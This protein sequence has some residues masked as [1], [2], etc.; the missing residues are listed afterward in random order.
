[1]FAPKPTRRA[2][3]QRAAIF[4]AATSLGCHSQASEAAKPANRSK[5][6][7]AMAPMTKGKIGFM[8]DEGD[9]HQRTWMAFGASVPIWGKALLPQ[10]QRNLAEL[11]KTIARYEPVSMLVRPYDYDLAHRLVG[12][13]VEL[14]I[15][16][17]D[18]LWIRD[19]G[20]VFVVTATGEK[21]ATQLNFNG[22]GRK[23]THA[24]DRLLAAFIAQQAGVPLLTTDLVLE[25]GCIEV[26]GQGTALIT[27]S[28][29]LNANRNPGIS[30]AQ[31][32]DQLMPL[33][34]LE[35]IIWLPGIRGADI[36][37]GHTDFYARF[38]G[39]GKVLAGYEPDPELADHVIT[40]QHLDILQAATDAQGKTLAVT[41]LEAPSRVRPAYAEDED[42]AAGYVGFYLCNGAVIMQEFGDRAADQ[43]AQAVLQNAFPDREI[44]ALNMDAIAAGGGS[45][46]CATQQEPLSAAARA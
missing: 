45:I 19:S 16:E 24:K 3:L 12:P 29:V 2:L 23:Q 46:H 39:P 5:M 13:S 9:P 36:T 30:K 28:C 43:A 35:K 37:D 15:A 42:F 4:A 11:A 31:F 41:V 20:P 7:P 33:L 26:D 8:P 38:T 21:A 34:G 10:V 25:G 18:D 17:L 44:V 22:W 27:E 1:M 40:K 6:P 32:E 14:V